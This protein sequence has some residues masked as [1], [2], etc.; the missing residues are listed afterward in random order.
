[1]CHFGL[2]WCFLRVF[3]CVYR[4]VIFYTFRICTDSKICMQM[5]LCMQDPKLLSIIVFLKFDNP[6]AV[7]DWEMY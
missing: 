1:M 2:K 4:C 6:I 3:L 5:T 7:V